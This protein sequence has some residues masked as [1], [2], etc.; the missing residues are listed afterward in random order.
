MASGTFSPG[1]A[2]ANALLARAVAGLHQALYRLLHSVAAGWVP[3]RE[4]LR[5]LN[6]APSEALSDQRAPE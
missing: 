6:S 5:R 3:A 4:D 1:L 2:S